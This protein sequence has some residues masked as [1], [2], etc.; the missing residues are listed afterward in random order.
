MFCHA[1]SKAVYGSTD[2]ESN[3]LLTFSL[4]NVK[5]HNFLGSH[6]TQYKEFLD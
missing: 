6:S 5:R 1:G 4:Y 2:V 3:L